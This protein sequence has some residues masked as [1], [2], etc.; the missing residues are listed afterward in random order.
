MR[1]SKM[2]PAAEEIGNKIGYGIAQWSFYRRTD[3]EKWTKE[4]NFLVSSLEGQ[5]NFSILK[6]KNEIWKVFICAV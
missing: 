2:N 1:E 6:C 5:L 3:L 4:N